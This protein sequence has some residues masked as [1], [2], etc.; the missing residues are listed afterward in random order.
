VIGRPAGKRR[1]GVRRKAPARTAGW[2][3]R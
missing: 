2:A 3:W 1:H